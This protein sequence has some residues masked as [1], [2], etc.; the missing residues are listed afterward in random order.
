MS[1]EHPRRDRDIGPMKQVDTA[2]HRARNPDGTVRIAVRMETDSF[3]EM[4][5]V[6]TVMLDPEGNEFCVV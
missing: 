4:Y 3:D 2:H 6:W 1:I 5:A